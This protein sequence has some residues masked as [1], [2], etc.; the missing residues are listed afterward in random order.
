MAS[1]KIG[2][3][4]LGK[5]GAPI[6]GH[7]LKGGFKLFVHDIDQTKA[8][9][10]ARRGAHVCRDAGSVGRESD[11]VIVMAGYDHEVR[12]ICAGDNGLFE[13]MQKGNIVA[14]CSTIK[15]NTIKDLEKKGKRRGIFVLDTPV[16]RAEE[17]AIAGNLLMM[18][19]GDSK[20]F[21]RARPIFRTFCSD[22][23]HFGPAGHGQVAKITHN[24]LLWIAV[25]ANCEALTFAEKLG[26]DK[27]ELAKAIKISTGTNGTVDRWESMTM[28]WIRKDLSIALE[29][30]ES[31]NM[32]LPMAG[33]TK[34]LV[35]VMGLPRVR[36][37]RL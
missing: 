11:I 10:L 21:R 1:P 35:N 9:A 33:L 27:K 20:A 31:L 29:F 2:L 5:M 12:E 18:G 6:G 15:V 30:A 26:L 8:Q 36:R 22:I 23:F 25:V 24:L 14:I 7:M 13:G 17:G 34:Q 37:R 19:S 3:I 28:P 32:G 4:G 16:T